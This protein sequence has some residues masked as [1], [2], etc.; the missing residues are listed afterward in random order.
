M[1]DIPVFA[2]ENGVGSLML[3][4][5]PYK[6]TAYIRIHDAS[7]ADAFLNECAGFCRA[8]GAEH[9]YATGHP[10]LECRPVHTKIIKMCTLRKDLPKTNAVVQPVTKETT[11]HWRELYNKRM[12]SVPGAA[13]MEIRD[14][15][16]LVNHATGYFVYENDV[17]LGI[18]IAE[19]DEVV[20]LAAV[21]PGAGKD[22]LLALCHTLQTDTIC[23]DVALTNERAVRLYKQVGFAVS[24][25]KYNWY[26]IM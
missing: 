22:V 19:N 9:I 15:N 8:V 16:S 11:N 12:V 3:K 5:V 18:G 4:E 21:K 20:A 2:T 14:V 23:L 26:E 7:N 13:S 1:R 24:K 10:S 25:E 17:L 6:Q